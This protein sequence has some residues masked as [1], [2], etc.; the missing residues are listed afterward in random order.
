MRK[1]RKSLL[2]IANGTA[3]LHL[4]GTPPQPIPSPKVYVEMGYALQC[5][6]AEQILLTQM[7]RPDLPGQF[8]FNLPSGSRLQ[9]RAKPELGKLLPAM[10]ETQLQRFNLI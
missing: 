1:I 3:I 5:K 2:F 7:D 9:F 4:N 8:P 6:R 10:I